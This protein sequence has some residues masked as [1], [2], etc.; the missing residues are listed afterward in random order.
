MENRIE[1]NGVW[2]IKENS[3]VLSKN[4]KSADLD[5]E[6]D[7]IYYEGLTWEDDTIHLKAE[8]LE[9]NDRMTSIS[10]RNK[11]TGKSEY[12][13]ND[14]WIMGVYDGD[15]VSISILKEDITFN[16]PYYYKILVRFIGEM[17]NRKFI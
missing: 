8:A 10:Y 6:R 9:G 12:W 2:Y 14:S 1:I 3:S 15:A 11:V 5:F 17:I 13:D 16:D 7:I 4:Q